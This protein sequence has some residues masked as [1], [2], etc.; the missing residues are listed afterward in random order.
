MKQLFLPLA[1]FLVLF[2]CLQSISARENQPPD[3]EMQQL[4]SWMTGFFTSEAQSLADTNFYNIH[5]HMVRIWRERSDAVWLY[6]EQAASWSLEKPYRQRIYRLTQLPDGRFESKVYAFPNP[7]EYA[8]AYQNPEIFGRL[9]QDS[10]IEREGCA[11]ILEH[12]GEKYTG[13][14]IGKNCRSNLRGAAYATSFVSISDSL[15]SSWDRGFDA[16]DRQV[17]GAV[18][19]P[20]KFR[21]IKDYQ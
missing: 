13:S 10:L 2:F 9:S 14:T 20:Y 8:G 17:W 12:K 18:T 21:K 4:V 1:A 11:M 7:L 3:T 16:D 15:L 19:G 6:I 5:L